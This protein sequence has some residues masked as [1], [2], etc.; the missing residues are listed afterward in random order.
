MCILNR[1]LS[2]SDSNPG[3][4]GATPGEPVYVIRWGFSSSSVG[5]V[6][7][8]SVLWMKSRGRKKLYHNQPGV[9]PKFYVF[10]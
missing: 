9:K 6:L 4:L 2:P 1:R 5:E 10:F 3:G 8:C 7:L